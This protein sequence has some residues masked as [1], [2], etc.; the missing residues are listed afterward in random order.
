MRKLVADVADVAEAPLVEHPAPPL[1]AERIAEQFSALDISSQKGSDD[2]G[3][4][5]AI[6]GPVGL[7]GEIT[8]PARPMGFAQVGVE[9]APQVKRREPERRVSGTGNDDCPR[10]DGK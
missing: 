5:F 10:L 2:R 7:V 4:V 3:R 8:C 1:A 6:D 9:N